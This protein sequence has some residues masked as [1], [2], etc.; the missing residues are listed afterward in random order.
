MNINKQVTPKE[1]FATIFIDRRSQVY[2]Q[3]IVCF[4]L[5]RA[6]ASPRELTRPSFCALTRLQG[7]WQIESPRRWKSRESIL[8]PGNL[9]YES[10]EGS[11]C[12]FFGGGGGIKVF[13]P[14]MN[15]QCYRYRYFQNSGR[16]FLKS[17]VFHGSESCFSKKRCSLLRLPRHT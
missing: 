4:T 11:C 3:Y 7:T 17:S 8:F 15:I 14:Y 16:T 13:Q 9:P 10:D 6:R 5:L 1:C 2:C 12:R